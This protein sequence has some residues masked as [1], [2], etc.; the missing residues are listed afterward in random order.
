MIVAVVPQAAQDAVRESMLSVTHSDLFESMMR[1]TGWQD[2]SGTALQEAYVFPIVVISLF[3]YMFF[4]MYGIMLFRLAVAFFPKEQL[5]PFAATVLGMVALL[6]FTQA[7]FQIYDPPVLAFSAACLL[8]MFGQRWFAYL[9]C[10]ALACFSKETAIL[11]IGLFAVAYYS[12]LPRKEFIRLLVTQLLIYG[13]ILTLLFSVYADAPSWFEHD[14]WRVIFFS[15]RDFSKA[16]MMVLIIVS[17]L[18]FSRWQ[19]LPHLLRQSLLVVAG[20]TL[21]YYLFGRYREY[22]VF[23]EAFPSLT[24]IAVYTMF[25]PRNHFGGSDGA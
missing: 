1:N 3:M 8:F 11:Q 18:T 5:L 10:F 6:P 20:C 21:I 25:A 2:F 7:R 9:F 12:V 23:F 22:R 17:W 15:L 13:G 24:L 4:A 14:P 16:D 19:E